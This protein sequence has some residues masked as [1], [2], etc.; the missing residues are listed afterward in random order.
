MPHTNPT[1]VPRASC[2]RCDR[3]LVERA[4]TERVR[5]Q[6]CPESH[7][8]L[9]RKAAAKGLSVAAVAALAEAAHESPVDGIVCPDCRAVTR[10]A[11]ARR[12]DEVVEL[13]ACAACGAVWFDHGEYEAL[14]KPRLAAKHAAAT[15][16][17][18]ANLRGEGVAAVAETGWFAAEGLGPLLEG[19]ASL[20]D[21]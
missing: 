19:L 2:P 3:D 12:G 18:R 13:D 14:T 8:A 1:G 21:G 15:A 7:G 5:V 10:V 20:F 6:A 9:L 4:L 11:L 16:Q 17:G